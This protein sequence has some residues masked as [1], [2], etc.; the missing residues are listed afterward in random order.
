VQL[1]DAISRTGRDEG[2]HQLEFVYNKYER[3]VEDEVVEGV[4]VD[5]GAIGSSMKT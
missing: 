2:D 1:V 3:V 4:V 5:R